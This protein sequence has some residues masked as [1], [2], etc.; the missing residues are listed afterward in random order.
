MILVAGKKYPE[1]GLWIC[2]GAQI[3]ADLFFFFNICESLSAAS[4][5]RLPH[6]NNS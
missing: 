2:V 1:Q 5:V 3:H 4:T 6:L